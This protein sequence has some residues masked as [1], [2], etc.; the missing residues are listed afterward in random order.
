MTQCKNKSNCKRVVADVADAV[1]D[2]AGEDGVAG[3]DGAA[4]A[5]GDDGDQ[6]EG[7]TGA[8]KGPPG[9]AHLPAETST[10]ESTSWRRLPS[11]PPGLTRE[12][13]RE[14]G[15]RGAAESEEEEEE[16]EEKEQ[17]LLAATAATAAARSASLKRLT[18]TAIRLLLVVIPRPVQPLRH[19]PRRRRSP[20]LRFRSA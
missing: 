6:V 18:E 11:P 15:R 19:E 5:D 8:T 1:A 14:G 20:S 2:D 9:A 10:S 12:H 3:D 17:R 4:V 7:R 13:V 16:E